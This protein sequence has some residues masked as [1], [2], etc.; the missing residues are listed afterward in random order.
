M[1]STGPIECADGMKTLSA[2][3]SW[4]SDWLPH[5]K[6]LAR[7]NDEITVPHISLFSAVL[8]HLSVVSFLHSVFSFAANAVRAGFPCWFY[9]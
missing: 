8:I 1:R 3:Q 2:G 9:N 5:N 4:G 7:W 6:S